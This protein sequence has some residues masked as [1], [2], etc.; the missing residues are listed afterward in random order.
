MPFHRKE[1]EALLAT[2]LVGPKVVQRLEEIGVDS[3]EILR[4]SDYRDICRKVAH[5]LGNS[6]WQNSPQAQQSMRN[7][8]ATAIRGV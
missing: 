7:A 5:R 2:P 6:C 3:F 4:R 1:R 8:I